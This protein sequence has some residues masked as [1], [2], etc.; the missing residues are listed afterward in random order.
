EAESATRL[1][2]SSRSGLT[3]YVGRQSELATVQSYV[4]RARTGVGAVV[5]VVGEAGAGKSRLLHELQPGL[6][7][8]SDLSILRARCRAYADGV[9]YG[10]FVQLL[11]ASLDLRPP[12]EGAD[13][14]A[15][16]IRALDAG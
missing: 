9:P 1:E 15:G 16:R 11:C 14:V 12:L 13:V 5:G 2:L 7:H 6:G 8:A 4:A 10:V 3:P